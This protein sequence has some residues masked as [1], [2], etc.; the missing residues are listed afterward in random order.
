MD[1]IQKILTSLG[2]TDYALIVLF[3]GIFIDIT[4]GIKFNPIK[5]IFKYLGKSFNSSIETEMSELKKEVTEKFEDLKKEQTKQKEALH[6]IILDSQ[7]R[8]ISR[9]RWEIIDFD[10]GIHNNKI[11][12]SKEQYRHV[13]NAFS[14]YQLILDDIGI[15]SDDYYHDV[16]K[17]GKNIKEHFEEHSDTGEA[18]F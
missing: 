1:Q 12:H 6:K 9:L 14:K 11:K 5:A 4:P 17:H 15:T 13:L 2:Y 16:M 7:D 10:N 18:Y 3:L 8:E